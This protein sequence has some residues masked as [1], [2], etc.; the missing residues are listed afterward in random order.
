MV[1]LSFP[2]QKLIK[3]INAQLNLIKKP[4]LLIAFN[5]N[6]RGIITEYIFRY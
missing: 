6:G 5:R 3:T 1:L 4:V 2:Y